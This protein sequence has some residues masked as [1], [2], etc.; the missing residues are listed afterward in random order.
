MRHQGNATRVFEPSL[1]VHVP[2]LTPK[3]G[4]SYMWFDE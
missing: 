2:A 4:K 1:E 3:E